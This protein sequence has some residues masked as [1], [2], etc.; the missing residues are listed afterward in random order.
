VWADDVPETPVE[1]ARSGWAPWAAVTGE[2]ARGYVTLVTGPRGAG[3]TRA[4]DRAIA[5]VSAVERRA[6]VHGTGEQAAR[7][8]A[9]VVARYA[10]ELE[11][12][13]RH[14][15]R[16]ALLPT[17]RVEDVLAAIVEHRA[18]C[19]VFDGIQTFTFGG[20]LCRAG[21]SALAGALDAIAASSRRHD[22]AAVIVPHMTSGG[23]K[24][25]GGALLQ[26][27]AD[28]IVRLSPVE[29]AADATDT[30]PALVR[31]SIDGKN[32]NGPV[33]VRRTLE[34]TADGTLIESRAS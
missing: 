31:L 9:R 22:W 13:H 21:S 14:R 23:E 1:R 20:E 2:L 30:A 33:T 11:R 15:P 8:L 29:L 18:L 7:D 24:I 32:R 27:L 12:T 16:V 19:G 5:G 4:V 28:T 10:A 6:V 26:Q 3:K 17:R 34:W 25:G